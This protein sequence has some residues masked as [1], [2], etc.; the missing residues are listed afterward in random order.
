MKQEALRQFRQQLEA[1]GT[2]IGA[3]V[4]AVTELVRGSSGG[5][6]QGELSNA[7]FHL[8]DMGTEE[9]L[10]DLNTTVLENEQHLANEIVAALRR[11]E[12]G[13][14]GVCAGCGKN[15]PRA[16]LK[17]VPYALFC[18]TCAETKQA[19]TKVNLDT[20]RPHRPADTLAP[21]GE[22]DEDR[23]PLETG[24]SEITSVRE[25]IDEGDVHA[26][27]TPGGGTALGGLA[28]TNA[29]RGDPDVTDLNEA[30]GSG[31]Y[32]SAE[33]RREENDQA[34]RAGHSGGAVGGTPAR[35]RA[36]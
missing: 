6:A 33:S 23:R 36:K 7:P 5:Q 24:M 30:F 28:G 3:D 22:M 18:V 8:G 35:K 21:E 26:S 11:I 10:H 17:A 34:P 16:R 13:T 29:G 25:R 14:Y 1:L 12:D 15:I 32:D 2:R 31:N 4:A 19:G 27:G 20:G 9:Y